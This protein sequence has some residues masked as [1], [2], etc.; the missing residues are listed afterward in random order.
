MLS[1]PPYLLKLEALRWGVGEKDEETFAAWVGQAAMKNS[2]RLSYK[3]DEHCH[4]HN[5]QL[6][7]SLQEMGGVW[8]LGWQ[9]RIT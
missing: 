7:H 2:I 3:V 4:H 1:K 8:W 9:H 6:G 5:Q